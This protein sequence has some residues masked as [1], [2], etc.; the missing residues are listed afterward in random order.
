MKGTMRWES[1]VR[2]VRE[3]KQEREKGMDEDESLVFREKRKARLDDDGKE[4]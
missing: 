3:R 4:R 2:K 1:I